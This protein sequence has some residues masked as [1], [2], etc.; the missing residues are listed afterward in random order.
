MH[1]M[2]SRYTLSPKQK[3]R[4]LA[5]TIHEVWIDPAS[6]GAFQRLAAAQGLSM[7]AALIQLLE[8]HAQI[9]EPFSP[10]RPKPWTAVP[11]DERVRYTAALP[12][13]D[14]APDVAMALL[15]DANRAG[16]RLTEAT[17]QLVW[18]CIRSST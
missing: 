2:T 7:R 14:V 11:A 10:R 12:S 9:R 6:K 16:I 15:I 13:V 3:A 8:Q 5:E 18:R 4:R 1:R 17:R